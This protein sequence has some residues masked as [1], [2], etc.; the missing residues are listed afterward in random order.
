MNIKNII[1]KNN[2]SRYIIIEVE[3]YVL[4]GLY[5]KKRRAYTQNHTKQ[6]EIWYWLG[7][8]APIEESDSLTCFYY[9]KL[10]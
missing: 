2:D 7:N 1:I 4:F 5:T 3:Y 8:D 6:I 10:K 9:D